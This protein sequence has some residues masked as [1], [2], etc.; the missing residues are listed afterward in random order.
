MESKDYAQARNFRIIYDNNS[1][2]IDFDEFKKCSTDFNFG[3][4]DNEIQL[5]FSSFDR[6]NTGEIDY[7]EFLITI[8]RE[9]ND[10]RRDS[11]N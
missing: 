11:V 3:L 9:M 5:A 7:D 10:F 4:N 2:T 6:D 8:R 1:Q